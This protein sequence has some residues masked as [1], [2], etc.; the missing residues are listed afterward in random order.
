M[1]VSDLYSLEGGKKVMRTLAVV[2]YPQSIPPPL[3]A[4]HA[5]I[6]SGHSIGKVFK[7]HG[8]SIDKRNLY[9]GDIVASDNFA[10]VY[11]AMGGIHEVNLAVHI[12]QLSVGKNGAWFR[13][14]RIA[15][16]HHPDYL[17]SDELREIYGAPAGEPEF[18]HQDI[19]AT[20][21]TVV[22]VMAKFQPEN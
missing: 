2:I 5:E 10:G 20:L 11:S 13:Y 18:S 12:Y 8:W 4:E 7:S 16:V 19:Q 6:K 21:N 9:F 1:R 17:G 3:T 22:G 14:A 15:E